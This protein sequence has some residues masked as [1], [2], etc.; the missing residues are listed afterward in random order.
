MRVSPDAVETYE[1]EVRQYY[2]RNFILAL[3]DNTMFF[4]IYLGLSPYTVLPFYLGRLTDSQVLIGLIPATYVLGFALPQVFVARLLQRRRRRKGLLVAFAA[5]QRV[6]ILGFLLLTGVQN[7]L[8]PSLT[9]VLFFLCF[10]IQ[11]VASGCWYPT[12]VDFIGRSIPR[13]RGM[14]FGWS[15]FIG[16]VFSIVGGVLLTYLLETL[17]YPGAVTAIAAIAFVASLISLT[18]ILGWHEVVPPGELPEMTSVRPVAHVAAALRQDANFRNY[19]IWRGLIIGL[20]MALP[21]YSL[22]ALQ[23]LRLADAQL[24]IFTLILSVSQTIMHPVWGWLGD[25][26]GYLT[27]VAAAAISGALGAFLAANANSVVLY[28]AVFWCAGVMLSG[29]QIAGINIIYELSSAAQ[30]PMYAAVSQ[31]TLSPLSALAPLVGGFLA[32]RFGYVTDFWIAGLVGSGGVLGL[33]LSLRNPSR[34]PADAGQGL[35]P[36]QF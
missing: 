12:W 21:F 14:L 9:I 29:L 31:I 25:R 28:Y 17:P 24:G 32:R 30:V 13:N 16:G 19:L 35:R 15:N 22:H 20:E 27:I 36:R 18:A 34:R 11:H 4:F 23:S 2:W 10:T 6:G 8:P 5:A 1:A 33:L 26:K 7:R 3:V